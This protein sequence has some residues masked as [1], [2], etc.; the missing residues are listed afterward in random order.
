MSWR[1]KD[2]GSEERKPPKTWLGKLWSKY[3]S[4]T[5]LVGALLFASVVG[6][7][8]GYSRLDN[9]SAQKSMELYLDNKYSVSDVSICKK[10][11]QFFTPGH[12][13]RELLVFGSGTHSEDFRHDIRLLKAY[14]EKQGCE[15]AEICPDVHDKKDLEIALEQ[16]A[17]Y[18]SDHTKTGFVFSGHG[19]VD[20]GVG[21]MVLKSDSQSGTKKGLVDILD[22]EATRIGPEFAEAWKKVRGHKQ[23]FFDMC[24]SLTSKLDD[25]VIINSSDKDSKSY[26]MKFAD[27]SYGIASVVYTASYLHVSLAE[28]AEL[29]KNDDSRLPPDVKTLLKYVPEAYSSLDVKFER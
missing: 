17:A 18:S 21:Y 16:L 13:C 22:K 14:Y 27:Y 9:W 29:I 24:F 25:T 8:I 28:A 12:S 2:S 26:T 1:S 19:R 15:V 23:A 6:A 11:R 7:N 5:R 20:G 10:K 3:Y 4:K